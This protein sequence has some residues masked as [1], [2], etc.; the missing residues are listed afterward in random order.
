MY[1]Q[2]LKSLKQLK[3][4]IAGLKRLKAAQSVS[5]S[6]EPLLQGL[7]HSKPLRA[8]VTGTGSA[9]LMPAQATC[10]LCGLPGGSCFW[11]ESR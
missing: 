6:L 1:L 9:A 8:S 7:K 2:S 4:T 11:Q 10:G 5:K 3:A